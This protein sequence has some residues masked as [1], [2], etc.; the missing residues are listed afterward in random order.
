MK[1]ERPV[2]A[3]IQPAVLPQKPA[4]S[5]KRKVLMWAFVGG[6]LACG[7]YGL[8][9]DYYLKVKKELKERMD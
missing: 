5:R 9:K 8:G 3:V 6:V 2:Y 7:W 1:E 4:N